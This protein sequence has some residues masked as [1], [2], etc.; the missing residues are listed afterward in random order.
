MCNRG[1]E[2]FCHRKIVTGA[3]FSADVVAK[4]SYE[5]PL[6][7]LPISLHSSPS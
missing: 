6:Y 3:G 2:L 5:Y 4:F 1:E 7:M